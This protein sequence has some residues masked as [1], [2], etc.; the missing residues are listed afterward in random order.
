MP[1]KPPVSL[2]DIAKQANVSTMTVSLS[3]RDDSSISE[4]TRTRVKK[5]A[6]E[7]GYRR[8]PLL[9]AY[10]QQ[11]RR[12]KSQA[13]HSTLAW[14]H[15][16]STPDVYKQAPWLRRYWEGARERAKSL[17]FSLDPIWLKE[18]KLNARR[19]NDILVARGIR[20]FLV[21]QLLN[22]EFFKDFP[23][24]SYASVSIGQNQLSPQI[25]RIIP[26]I[27]TNTVIALEELV[28]RGYRRIGYYQNLYHT[29]KTQSEGV[30]SAFFHSYRITGEAPLPPCFVK[31]ESFSPENVEIICRWVK[32]I[33]PEVILTENDDIMEIL[34]NMGLRIP[35]D[36]GIAHL[37]ITDERKNWSGINPRPEAL[38]ASAI[39]QLAS[40]IFRNEPG[41]RYANESF[42]IIGQWVEGSTLRPPK[43]KKKN[44]TNPLENSPVFSHQYFEKS[45]FR[46]PKMGVLQV[47]PKDS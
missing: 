44:K 32:E 45:L 22:P 41:A 17:G 38:A 34:K 20:G 14:F 6:E 47:K 43:E 2:R 36:I 9:S 15:D 13:F 40:Q 4:A 3:L 29:T 19:L 10:G 11:I 28:S 18:P 33:K 23:V 12:R 8:D 1:E 5:I 21:H 27:S 37:E 25:P 39:D 24:T 31:G 26:A 46:E 30:A 35:Q 16:W 42:R 7:M